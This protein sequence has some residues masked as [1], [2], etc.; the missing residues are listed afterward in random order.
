MQF[1]PG[2]S[3]LES[4]GQEPDPKGPTSENALRDM[5]DVVVLK[6]I[7]ATG[8]AWALDFKRRRGSR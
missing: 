8:L 2:G 5:L 3:E 7:F 4:A 1:Q 6:G